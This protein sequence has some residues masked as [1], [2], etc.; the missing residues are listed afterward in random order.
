LPIELIPKGARVVLFGYGKR[1]KDFFRQNQLLQWCDIVL[2]VDNH[3]QN[4]SMEAVRVENPIE[5]KCTEFDFVLLAIADF[6]IKE[7]VEAQLRDWGVDKEKIINNVFCNWVNIPAKV[8]ASYSMPSEKIR[9]G[10]IPLGGIGDNI[11]NLKLY[12]EIV[13]LAPNSEIDVY[14]QQSGGANSIFYGQ[15]NLHKIFSFVSEQIPLADYDVVLDCNFEPGLLRCNFERVEKICPRLAERLHVLYEYQGGDFVNLPIQ[16]YMNR[17]RIERARLMGWNRYTLYGGSGAFDIKDQYV[18]FFMDET[19][20]KE[21][22]KLLLNKPYITY[23]YGADD[24]SKNVKVQNKMWPLEYHEKFNRM[25]KELFP[26][27]E[28]VQIG[29]KD[30]VRVIGADRYITGQNLEVV[31]YIL[32][33]SLCHVDC[34][35]GMVHMATQLGT[36]CVVMFGPTPVWFFGYDRNIN[37]APRVCGECQGVITDWYTRCLKYGRPECMYSIAPER[38]LDA[39]GTCLKEKF[40]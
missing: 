17:L 11:I 6:K 14:S 1:G 2:V 3:F 20:E 32:K 18:D 7:C 23:N 28:L 35:G 30:V 27:V 31:K 24:L 15:S 39:V 38:V 25:F 16:E 37:L 8:I 4:Y 9:I 10:F 33:N 22:E 19:Y 26:E 34:E 21:Y 12:Q 40:R 5:I 36:K 29:A 13:K